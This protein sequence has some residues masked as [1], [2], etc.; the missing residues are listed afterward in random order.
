MNKNHVRKILEQPHE[1]LWTVQGFGKM[2]TNVTDNARL[3]I[4]DRLLLNPRVPA[5]HSHSWDFHSVVL[6]GCVRNLRMCE[7]ACDDDPWNKV[8]VASSGGVISEPTLTWLKEDP[9]EIYREGAE[10]S[11]KGAE[12]HWSCPDDGSVT[13]VEWEFGLPPQHMKVF[14]RGRAGWMD[15]K[16]RQATLDE[17]LTVAQRSLDLWF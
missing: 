2:S 7:A 14:W 9:T 8:L 1:R 10:Y 3:H 6:V 17:I 12:I 15:A 5:V 4:W 16:P 13:L 11:Q